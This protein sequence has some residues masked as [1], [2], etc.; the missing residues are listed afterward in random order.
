MLGG[1]EADL[2]PFVVVTAANGVNVH[3]A[4]WQCLGRAGHFLGESG[5]GKSS[6]DP[7]SPNYSLLWL[8]Q[9]PWTIICCHLATGMGTLCPISALDNLSQESAG[10]LL[11]ARSPARFLLTCGQVRKAATAPALRELPVS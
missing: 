6:L 10:H 4:L 3:F 9:E 2:T 5:L 7:M 11:P 1:R 8:I